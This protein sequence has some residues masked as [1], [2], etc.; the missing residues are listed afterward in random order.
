MKIIAVGHMYVNRYNRE[1]FEMLME[2]H[3]VKIVYPSKWSGEFFEKY[4]DERGFK[5]IKIPKTKNGY[6]PFIRDRNQYDILWIDEEPYLP[7]TYFILKSIIFK[8]AILRS[9]QNILK[10]DP[11]RRLMFDFVKKR[12]D[13]FVAVGE[14]SKMVLEKIFQRD[15]E[16]VPL[17]IPDI[18]F[19]NPEKNFSKDK[20]TLGFAARL[21]IQKGV[22][23]LMDI[24][25]DLNEDFKIK[26]AGNGKMEKKLINLLKDKKIEYEFCGF[27]KHEEMPNFYRDVDIFL[28][29]S[30]DSKDWKE[31]QGRTVI[32]AMASNCVVL[33]TKSFDIEK[34]FDDT[35]IYVEPK[36]REVIWKL[37]D[38]NR[39]REKLYEYSTIGKE[40][41][42]E[43][44]KFS[45][46]KRIN[47]IIQKYAESSIG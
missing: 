41:A 26:I 16:I 11:Y 6:I 33:T 19:S 29:L 22:L 24:L 47:R 13:S 37:N 8:K 40:K 4:F 39:N 35:V 27:I 28:N 25:K 17:H 43:F 1:I 46:L 36:T 32:E 15:V 38:L 2:E 9:A 3:E 42:K 7:Q 34:N 18:F 10:M 21:E 12:I 45:I 31:Q 5:K 23:L 44:S 20:L 30:I 14:G